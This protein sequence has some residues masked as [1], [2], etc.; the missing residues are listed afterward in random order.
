GSSFFNVSKLLQF[1]SR[2]VILGYFAGITVAIAVTQGFSFTGI[3]SPAAD[4]TILFQGWY[5]LLHLGQTHLWTLLIG[6]VSL[7]FLILVRTHFPNWPNALLMIVGAAL[8]T[9]AL[10]F[11]FGISGLQTL[12]SYELPEEPFFQVAFPLLDLSLISKIFPAA[13]ALAFLS[14][15]EVYS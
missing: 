6:A 2:P 13:L 11:F 10:S 9:K 7:G 14:I 4:L 8:L 1:V 5:L 12:G 3:A 15:L